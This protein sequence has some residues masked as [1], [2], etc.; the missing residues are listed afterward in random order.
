M[1][2][3]DEI[4]SPRNLFS[5]WSEFKKKGKINKKD[6]QI[7]SA[8]L[9]ENVFALH[10]ELKMG[11]Y[12][13]GGYEKFVVRDPKRRVIHKAGVRD[14]LLHRAVFRILY[15]IFDKTFIFD[16][17]ASRESKGIHKAIK[18]FKYFARKISKN[19]TRTIYILKCDV[20]KF[21]DN[22]DHGILLRLLRTKIG[23][24]K[25]LNLL[26][27][28][29][30]S[31]ETKAGK[32]IPL[33]N[34]TSQLF[35]NVY[36]NCFD[37]YIKRKLRIKFYIRYADDFVVMLSD[38]EE[39]FGLLPKT[40]DFMENKLSLFLHS[41]KVSVRKWRQ[42]IDFLG[43]VSRP[44]YE[45]LRAKTARRIFRNIEKRKK[46]FEK[47]T[48]TEDKLRQTIQS[49]KGIFGHCKG[50]KAKRK[51]KRVVGFRFYKSK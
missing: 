36:L 20:K 12:Q 15:P 1:E 18:R 44:N 41:D 25:V 43:F 49:Y 8:E 35:S 7:F 10:E 4:T 2:L 29:I 37:N 46:E 11:T 23:D 5:A 39:L 32:G 26:E 50:L 47:M 9:E 38:D 33:G 45:I 14:R 42:G 13:H 21:F 40:K 17:Y 30:A 28:I 6:V 31:F 48:I 24:P 16:S 27:N 3:Y 22:I 34:L 19:N 51:I